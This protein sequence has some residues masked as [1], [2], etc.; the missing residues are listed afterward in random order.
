MVSMSKEDFDAMIE[1]TKMLAELRAE[2]ARVKNENDYLRKLVDKLTEG[3][4]D[5]D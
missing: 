4:H 5:G 2:N 1:V 3:K